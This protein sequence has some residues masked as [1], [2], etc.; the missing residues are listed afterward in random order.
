MYKLDDMSL[1]NK[2]HKSRGDYHTGQLWE[3]FEVMFD[4][5]CSTDIPT[6]TRDAI[7]KANAMRPDCHVQRRDVWCSLPRS[8]YASQVGEGRMLQ[9]M[10]SAEREKYEMYHIN[11]VLWCGQRP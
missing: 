11:P 1:Q 2:P 3:G 4:T 8:H 9:V 5:S 6:N 7:R 10:L